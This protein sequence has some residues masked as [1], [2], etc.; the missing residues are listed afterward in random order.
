MVILQMVAKSLLRRK[1]RVLIAL[2]ATSVSV[3]LVLL[4]THLKVGVANSL[5]RVNGQADLIVGA[6]AQPVHLALYGIFRLGNPPPV[7]SDDHVQ[8]LR[9]HPEIKSVIPLSQQESHRGYPVTATTEQLFT[10]T[11]AGQIFAQGEGFSQPYS[12]V[13]GASFARDSGYLPGEL[14]TIA[15]G[16][17]PSLADEYPERFTIT[18]VLAPTGSVLDNDIFVPLTTLQAI[19]SKYRP[20]DNHGVNLLLIKLHSKQATL[21]IQSQIKNVYGQSLEV[22]IPAQELAYVHQLANRVMNTVLGILGMTVLMALLMVFFSVSGSLA[23]RRNE[24]QTLRMLGARTHQIVVI[25][26]LEPL[27][28]ILLASLGG[29]LLFVTVVALLAVFC[30]VEWQ[31]W[32]GEQ[33]IS[34]VELFTWLSVLAFGSLLTFVPAWMAYG[35]CS[36]E[37]QGKSR[38]RGRQERKQHPTPRLLTKP[39]V[40]TE[41]VF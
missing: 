3:F 35:Q 33:K 9:A 8:R 23:E 24:V 4:L 12:V 6:P 22:I 29:F 32:I 40:R 17:E 14:M 30:P 36:G 18:G 31:A 11:S 27:V 1:Q 2:L 21:P 13:L 15:A 26:F 10:N 34:M 16:A 7:I 37:Q 20:N 41:D 28:V 25:G 39:D 5:S 38:Q 19:R